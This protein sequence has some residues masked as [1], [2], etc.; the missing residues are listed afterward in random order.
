MRS[1]MTTS[2]KCHARGQKRRRTKGE[3]LRV[4]RVATLIS[5]QR[6]AT[7]VVDCRV[8]SPYCRCMDI[9]IR[10]PITKG[11]FVDIVLPVIGSLTEQRRWLQASLATAVKV[12]GTSLFADSDT[13][14][15]IDGEERYV[16]GRRSNIEV[17]VN[18]L[19]PEEGSVESVYGDGQ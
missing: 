13:L 14:V 10:R 12:R 6:S 4:L 3:S 9:V 17:I 16:V 15:Y 18:E 19:F 1:E 11:S 8:A 5:M 2:E 7:H